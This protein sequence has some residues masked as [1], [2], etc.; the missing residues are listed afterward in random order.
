[1]PKSSTP[2]IDKVV[3][4]YLHLIKQFYPGIEFVSRFSLYGGDQP[5]TCKID[6]TFDNSNLKNTD[7]EATDTKHLLHYTSSL[8]NLFSILN[9]GFLRLSNLNS[10][11]DPQEFTHMAKGINMK[12]KEL[13]ENCKSGLHS[14]SFC[15][16]EDLEKPDKFPMWRLYGG[17]GNGAAILFEVDNPHGNWHR[18]MMAK[19]QYGK[20]YEW[21]RY[22]KFIEAHNNFQE[23][24]NNAIANWAEAITGIMA[25][26][27][28]Q[29]W[30]YEDE[31]RFLSYYEY[32]KYSKEPSTF[33]SQVAKQYHSFTGKG[34]S[35]SYLELPLFGTEKY[36][37]VKNLYEEHS[38]S[39][40][41]S[42]VVPALKIKKII[43]G[44]N[45]DSDAFYESLEM[46]SKLSKSY[47]YSIEI[48]SSYLEKYLR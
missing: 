35:F 23:K 44:Y 17:D 41:F 4:E 18:Y 33:Q 48:A 34:K 40:R 38:S 15:K 20:S 9:S 31:L 25:M 13:I 37:N 5:L 29:I 22:Q 39:A 21:D 42:D 2:F 12:D 32:D 46:I 24:H 16:V 6:L 3:K 10:L 28:N 30:N 14:V 8:Q 1:M 47:G 26:H 11:N 43:L 19:V 36:L 45:N 7:Y 27:K